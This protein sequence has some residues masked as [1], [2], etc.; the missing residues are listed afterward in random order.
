MVKVFY[1]TPSNQAK[2]VKVVVYSI[3]KNVAQNGIP[4]MQNKQYLSRAR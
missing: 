2:L 3:T 4:L 1:I